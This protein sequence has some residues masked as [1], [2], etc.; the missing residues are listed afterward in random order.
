MC[1]LDVVERKMRAT[2]LIVG[3]LTVK[4]FLLQDVQHSHTYEAQQ[5]S[6]QNAQYPGL[7]RRGWFSSKVGSS[8]FSLFELKC[9]WPS[10]KKTPRNL[11]QL[12]DC[13]SRAAD[14]ALNAWSGEVSGTDHGAARDFDKWLLCEAKNLKECQNL[15]KATELLAGWQH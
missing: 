1:F 11:E 9:S 14:P 8:Q 3:L 2:G 5:R 10:S 7:I 13:Q 15:R 6:Y 4:G 12:Y